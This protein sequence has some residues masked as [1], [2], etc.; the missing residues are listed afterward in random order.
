MHTGE[1]HAAWKFGTISQELEGVVQWLHRTGTA[2]TYM[3]IIK[4][5]PSRNHHVVKNTSPPRNR[6]VI[7][8]TSAPH[9]SKQLPLC[10]S[11]HLTTRHSR[12]RIVLTKDK[13]V[14]CLVVMI[15]IKQI[16]NIYFAKII[17]N[18]HDNTF[19]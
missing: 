13:Y 10:N 15:Y 1:V 16:W 3:Q 12:D 8:D 9:N 17:C 5:T 6:R 4:N 7:K 2:Q 14:S 18:I 19:L 11:K